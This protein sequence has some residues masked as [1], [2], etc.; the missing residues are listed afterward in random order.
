MKTFQTMLQALLLLASVSFLSSTI[1]A[2]DKNRLPPELNQNSSLSEI[3]DWLDRTSFAAARIGLNHSGSEAVKSPGYYKRGTLGEKFVFSQGFKL[4]NLDGCTLTLRNDD[5][6]LL[7]YADN[8][9][10]T[11]GGDGRHMFDE[12]GKTETRYVAELYLPLQKISDRRG[13]APYLHTSNPK[14]AGLI[15]SWRT[16]F[17]PKGFFGHSRRVFAISVFPAGEREKQE[18]MDGEMLTFTFDSRETS[19]KF[20][21]AFRRAFKL[22]GAK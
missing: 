12:V 20:N 4:A 2:Q 5:V 15:G 19:E 22:C 1:F 10:I 16:V 7:R 18:F 8:A 13:K 14:Q 6:K 11:I 3:I 9:L 17:Q 21:A